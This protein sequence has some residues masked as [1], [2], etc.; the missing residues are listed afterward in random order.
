MDG[1]PRLAAHLDLADEE[2]VGCEGGGLLR[3]GGGGVV[4]VELF[5]RERAVH[6]G[7]VIKYFLNK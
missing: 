5:L 6:V 4:T 1:V 2:I 3:S 7:R